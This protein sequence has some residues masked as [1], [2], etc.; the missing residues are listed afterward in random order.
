MKS[1]IDLIRNDRN[2]NPYNSTK[3]YKSKIQELL[4]KSEIGPLT[5]LGSMLNNQTRAIQPG[6]LYM[7]TY[8]PKL[9]KKLPIYDKFPLLLP[10]NK[11]DDGFIG[12]N[13]HY[14]PPVHRI[15]LLQQLANVSPV[16]N[17]KM[18]HVD[19]L[20]IS[21]SLLNSISTLPD[22]APCVKRY[23]N[24]YVKTNFLELPINDW[25]IACMLP[26]ER[27]VRKR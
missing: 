5:M 26:T 14:I 10:F 17:K 19:S 1:I 25:P 22:F 20:R 6:K 9:K 11:Y 2:Y 4:G 23:L 12:L 3:W 7:F 15:E 24:G 27:F 16:V 18:G 13:L 21:W 8:D